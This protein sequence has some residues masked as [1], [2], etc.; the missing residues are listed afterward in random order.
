M[1]NHLSNFAVCKPKFNAVVLAPTF[2]Q[3][4]RKIGAIP[5][6]ISWRQANKQMTNKQTEVNS[7]VGASQVTLFLFKVTLFLFH[8]Y[9]KYIILAVTIIVA[10]AHRSISANRDLKIDVFF[11]NGKPLTSKSHVTK[12]LRRVCRNF[13]T[14][15]TARPPSSGKWFTSIY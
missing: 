4:F 7:P 6:E 1:E 10:I 12:S 8:Y 5:F 11:A 2:P 15:W 3:T 14:F 13:L 9:K